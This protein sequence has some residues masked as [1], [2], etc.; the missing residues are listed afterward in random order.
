MR[1]LPASRIDGAELHESLVADGC[2]VGR[3]SRIERC[4]LG[5]RSRVG[6]NCAIRDT[7]IIGSDGFET[8]AA[9]GGEPASAGVRT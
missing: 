8:D 4:I 9:A 5:V 3:G 1:N 2:V 6:A 7:V